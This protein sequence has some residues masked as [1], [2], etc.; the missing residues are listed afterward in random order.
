MPGFES[1]IFLTDC[2]IKSRS[3]VPIVATPFLSAPGSAG[4]QPFVSSFCQQDRNCIMTNVEAINKKQFF[5]L[6]I[7][8]ISCC[9]K[10]ISFSQNLPGLFHFPLINIPKHRIC[11]FRTGYIYSSCVV[12]FQDF[13]DF[14]IIVNNDSQIWRLRNM[15]KYDLLL[16]R[17]KVSR[18]LPTSR[19][20][21]PQPIYFH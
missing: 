8:L 15:L 14:I 4:G 20:P 9:E 11:V 3:G 10:S 13:S 12:L 1:I 21:F 6:F 18:C 17:Y 19:S 7:T 5:D 2:G 16:L